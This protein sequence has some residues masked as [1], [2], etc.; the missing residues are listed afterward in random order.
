MEMNRLSEGVISAA[1]GVHR[2]VASGLSERSSEKPLFHKSSPRSPHCT[3]RILR[4]I[5]S[6]SLAVQATDRIHALVENEP[7]LEIKAVETMRPAP[8]AQPL[9]DL[10]GTGKRQEHPVHFN[11]ALLKRELTRIPQKSPLKRSA[12]L[13]D[14][15]SQS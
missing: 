12:L 13:C 15:V 2:L 7:T 9:N 4:A 5:F 8:K 11:R 1:I 6:K 14:F 10:L 3:P